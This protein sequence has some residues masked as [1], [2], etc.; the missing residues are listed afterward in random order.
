MRAFT[1]LVTPA[2]LIAT[3]V[4]VADFAQARDILICST[5]Y[6]VIENASTAASPYNGTDFGAVA[7][8]TPKVTTF[9]YTNTDV[10][11][12]ITIT[13]AVTFSG[14]NAADF[15]IVTQPAPGSV[16]SNTINSFQVVFT[17][18]GTGLRT[19]TVTVPNNDPDAEANFTFAIQG[20]GVDSV[21]PEADLSGAS[22]L[23]AITKVNSKSAL[24]KVK[25][26]TTLYNLG[27]VAS[28]GELVEFF[29][30][31]DAFL[32][33]ADEKISERV[34]AGIAAQIP[35]KPAKKKSA[36]LSVT[37]PAPTSGYLFMRATQVPAESVESQRVNNVIRAAY[38]AAH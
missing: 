12:L 5:S 33:A 3:W 8:G 23:G 35:G 30:S 24:E 36:K 16:D 9:D 2:V 37:L 18:G 27:P 22:T 14:T 10:G 34:L 4:G 6:V 1:S 38:V 19:A 13:G 26:S 31:D 28:A 11:S 21:A 29:R 25:W 20:T 17:P 7:V 15:S 32:D